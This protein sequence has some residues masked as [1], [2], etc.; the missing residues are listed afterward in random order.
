MKP[1]KDTKFLPISKLS[2]YIDQE[3]YFCCAIVFSPETEN[4]HFEGCPPYIEINE[5]NG[6]RLYFE[7][8][9]IVAYYGK[10]HAAYT[11]EGMSRRIKQGERNMANKIKDL[12]EIKPTN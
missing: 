7:V 3:K 12:L 10:V 11:M 9:Q 4:D 1:T 8:P 5:M 6:K 2:K